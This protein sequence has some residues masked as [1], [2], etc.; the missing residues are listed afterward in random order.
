MSSE[1]P[2]T[3]RGVPGSLG[4]QPAEATPVNQ[5]PSML[6]DGDRVYYYLDISPLDMQAADDR[7]AARRCMAHLAHMAHMAHMQLATPAQLAR[8]GGVCARTVR[9]DVERPEQYGPAGF[10]RP[11]RPRRRHG[12][13]DREVLRRAARILL[14]GASRARATRPCASTSGSVACPASRRSPRRPPASRRRR[15]RGARDGEGPRD[16]RRARTRRGGECRGATAGPGARGAQPPRRDRAP[17]AG[18][19]ATRRV[20]PWP[21]SASWRS[22]LRASRRPRRWPRAASWRPCPALL[23]AGLLGHL[24]AL[25]V[26][27]GF[28]GLHSTL[29]VPAFLLPARVRNPERLGAEAPGEWGALPGLDRCPCPRTLRRKMHRP[30][31]QPEALQAWRSG[32]AGDWAADDPAAAATLFL[33]GHVQV[34]HGRGNLLKHCVP[35]LRLA[36]PASVSYWVAALG[37]A[38]LPCLHC[39]ADPG[40][41]RALADLARSLL[42]QGLL[43]AGPD[44]PEGEPPP[45]LTL[46]FDRDGWSPEWFRQLRR[47]GVAVV[48]WIKDKQG[49]R[50]PEA[51][52]KAAAITAQAPS[53]P[54]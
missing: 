27:K 32:L 4:L 15:P 6:R 53:G 11:R 38:R 9:R 49:Q 12:I 13:E 22:V 33:D 20:A 40:M 21:V 28:Y 43:P 29:L 54:V 14:E 10:D 30:G 52:F 18:P 51:D 50:W 1:L 48:T 31:E 26:G 42:A 3:P 5:R 41:V 36:L 16:R 24:G 7:R 17:G 47:Q 39:Q 34:Y 25:S 8:A 45:R 2:P 37:G 46:V 23:Q 35:R 19:P 44:P